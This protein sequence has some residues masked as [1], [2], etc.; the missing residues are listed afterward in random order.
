MFTI[1]V[2][3]SL[4]TNATMAVYVCVYDGENEEGVRYGGEER[5]RERR[6]GREEMARER[7]K[8]HTTASLSINLH[9]DLPS[10]CTVQKHVRTSSG[11]GYIAPSR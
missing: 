5:R 9:V 2:T 3:I 4:Y 1:Y 11:G 8:C 10:T 7:E 6:R